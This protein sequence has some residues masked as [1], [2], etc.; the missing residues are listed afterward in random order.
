MPDVHV[1]V[2]VTDLVTVNVSSVTNPL[3]TVDSTT[4]P[5]IDIEV[6]GAPG[7]QGPAGP[8]GPPGTTDHGAL[9]GLADDDHPQYLNQSRADQRYAII[10]PTLVQF[11]TPQSVWNIDLGYACNVV[12]TDSAGQVVEPGTITYSGTSM[13]L[14]FSGAFSGTAYCF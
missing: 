5:V 1:D 2:A 8:A 12:V 4:Q 6:V 11:P 9:T 14:V 3:V 7:A 13:Q 10:G